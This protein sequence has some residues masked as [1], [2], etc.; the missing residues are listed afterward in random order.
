VHHQLAHYSDR[1][2]HFSIAVYAL[3]MLAL[4]AEWAF[5]SRRFATTPAAAAVPA[6]GLALPPL[7]L[8]V[9]ALLSLPHAVR[10]SAAIA[11]ADRVV[12]SVLPM[13]LSFTDP[14][15]G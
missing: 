1:F 12:P 15:F 8:E 11:V 9:E 14:T 7:L 5:D 13:R 10:V 4:C 6:A 3:A 2:V